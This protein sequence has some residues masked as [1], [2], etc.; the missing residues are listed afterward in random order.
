V[1]LCFTLTVITALT[2]GAGRINGAETAPKQ[3]IEEQ[4][5]P[6]QAA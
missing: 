6:P 5:A 2:W 4:Q 1:V 3:P